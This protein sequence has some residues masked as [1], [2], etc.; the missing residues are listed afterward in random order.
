MLPFFTV[1]AVCIFVNTF[2]FFPDKMDVI[3][4]Q[5]FQDLTKK[6]IKSTFLEIIADSDAKFH[7]LKVIRKVTTLQRSVLISIL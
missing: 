7:R 5:N 4:Q 3:C 1:F 6:K 2:T